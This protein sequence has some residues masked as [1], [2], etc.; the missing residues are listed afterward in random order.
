MGDDA[1]IVFQG[2]VIDFN[3]VTWTVDVYSTFDRKI[4]QNVQVLSPY[5]HHNSGEGIYVIPEI[6]AKCLC[7]I[8]GDST[9]P[10]VMGFVGAL[11]SV[12]PATANAPQG[13][14]MNQGT[15]NTGVNFG[16]GRPRGKPGDIMLRG[17]DGNFVAL[18]RGGVLQIGASELAQSIY[19]PL[20][21]LLM[22]VTQNYAHH[23][24]GGAISWG[25]QQ[26]TTID[27]PTQYSHT[28]RLFA[29]DQYADVRVVTG[30]VAAPLGEPDGADGNTDQILAA[31]I[32]DS[33]DKPI[34]CEIAV[35]P[36]G[37][38]ADAATAKDD[39]TRKE[40]VFRFFFDRAGGTF[41]RCAGS[42]VM[43]SRKKMMF[44]ADE[45]ITIQSKNGEVNISGKNGVVINGGSLA[46]IKGDV[47]RLGA[48]Q[49]PLMR[50][51]DL[52]QIIMPFMPLPAPGPPLTLYGLGL[53]GSSN[54]YG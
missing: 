40:N 32:N 6:G 17:R 51:G 21:N 13:T 1:A 14:T 50:Q 46:H 42:L 24:S 28:F 8:P 16:A 9:S 4:I 7:C 54:V 26:G 30:K 36:L 35:T 52:V 23:N 27:N 20:S 45:D 44:L 47:I 48:G 38:N 10:F 49:Q 12:N 53:T 22:D 29:N 25:I 3:L 11:E 34:V 19:I 39:T 41:L 5:L 43:R 37:F 31:G 2:K 15:F 18:H 33:K